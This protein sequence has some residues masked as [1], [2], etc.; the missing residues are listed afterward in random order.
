MSEGALW[1]K[2]ILCLSLRHLLPLSPWDKL[3]FYLGCRVEPLGPGT[4]V[5]TQGLATGF[6]HHV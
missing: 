2:S 1:I 4:S 3:V 5:P 6:G